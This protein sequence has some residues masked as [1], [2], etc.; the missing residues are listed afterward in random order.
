MAE[1]SKPEILDSLDL[2]YL[3]KI[4]NKSIKYNSIADEYKSNMHQSEKPCL[5]CRKK[6]EVI[7]II[8]EEYSAKL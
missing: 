4:C 6:D 3:R 8:R 2:S 7:E 5:N 1:D